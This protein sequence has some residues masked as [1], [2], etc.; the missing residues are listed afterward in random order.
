VDLGEHRIVR[1]H[2]CICHAHKAVSDML[3]SSVA[4]L[5]R[6]SSHLAAQRGSKVKVTA[7]LVQISQVD[8]KHQFVRLKIPIRTL[9]FALQILQGHPCEFQ[10]ISEASAP[11]AAGGPGQFTLVYLPVRARG[12]NIR[13]CVTPCDEMPLVLLILHIAAC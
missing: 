8:L 7:G 4:R 6:L 13:M 2:V 11:A 3:A 9:D 10:V 1:P 5:G 12:E